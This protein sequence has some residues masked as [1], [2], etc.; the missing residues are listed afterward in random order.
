M[1]IGQFGGG[2]LDATAD[3]EWQHSPAGVNAG[4]AEHRGMDGEEVVVRIALAHCATTTWIRLAK[5][6]HAPA[7]IAA[8]A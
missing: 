7:V 5:T 8:S 4:H 3:A 2:C 6:V 1:E